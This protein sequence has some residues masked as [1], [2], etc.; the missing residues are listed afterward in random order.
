MVG[1]CWWLL[2]FDGSSWWFIIVA[3]GCWCFWWLL[4]VASVF[5]GCW[6]LLVV[7]VGCWWLLVVVGGCWWFL[8]IVCSCLRLLVVVGG[9]WWLLVVVGGQKRSR[10]KMRASGGHL[11]LPLIPCQLST[12]P[13]SSSYSITFFLQQD[14]YRNRNKTTRHNLKKDRLLINKHVLSVIAPPSQCHYS[15]QYSTSLILFFAIWVIFQ[16][17]NQSHSL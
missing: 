14:K 17:Q 11:P 12:P 1:S 15:L 8:V 3:C 7:V 6:L 5:D 9:C 2:V 4:V 13:S 10:S 16:L